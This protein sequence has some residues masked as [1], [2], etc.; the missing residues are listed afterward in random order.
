MS[1][2]FL[3]VMGQRMEREFGRPEVEGQDQQLAN[4]PLHQLYKMA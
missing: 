3:V 4:I 1:E 2:A